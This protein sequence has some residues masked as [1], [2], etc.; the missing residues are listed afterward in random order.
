MIDNCIRNKEQR[1]K[2]C[3]KN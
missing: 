3:R 2:E 1:C